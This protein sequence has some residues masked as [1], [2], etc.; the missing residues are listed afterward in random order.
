MSRPDTSFLQAY[1]AELRSIQQRR[2]RLEEQKLVRASFPIISMLSA[3]R[4]FHDTSETNV[5]THAQRLA[6]FEAELCGLAISGGGIRSAT[7]ALGVLQGLA[8]THMLPRFDY[9][10]TV[11]GGGYI[12]AW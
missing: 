6:S 2:K 11:S 7:F 12:G 1:E 5:P 4:D 10:S 9:L 8:A 3:E